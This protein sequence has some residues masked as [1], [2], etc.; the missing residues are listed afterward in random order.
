MTTATVSSAPDAAEVTKPVTR[1]DVVANTI[2]S[3]STWA[4]VTS[5][6]PVHGLDLAALAAVQANMI[7]DISSLY[8]QKLSNYAVKGVISTLLGT[9]ATQYGAKLVTQSLTK[10]IPFAGFLSVSS[11]AA[12]GYASTYAIGKV[13]ANHYAKGGTFD[14]FDANAASDE[15]KAN[16]KSKAKE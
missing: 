7:I 4:A 9:L 12:F 2:N 1:E 10:W 5:L 16:F 14:N 13:F 15:L 8:G 11:M 6:I 3:N